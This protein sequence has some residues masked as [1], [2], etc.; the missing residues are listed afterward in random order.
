MHTHTH[1]HT[2][3]F[4]RFT[5]RPTYIDL[6]HGYFYCCY[7]TVRSTR[8]CDHFSVQY[9]AVLNDAS[10][11]IL[12]RLPSPKFNGVVAWHYR[13]IEV[14]NS[15]AHVEGTRVEWIFFSDFFDISHSVHTFAAATCDGVLMSHASF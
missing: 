15:L 14:I 2:H 8:T 4:V 7:I 5:K 9:A 1:T 12:S 13:V 10:T 3:R 11:A 6:F